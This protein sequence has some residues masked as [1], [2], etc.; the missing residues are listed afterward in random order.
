MK[1]SM[2]KFKSDFGRLRERSKVCSYRRSP[3]NDLYWVSRFIFLFI[4]VEIFD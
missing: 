1:E 4:W 3:G 2:D